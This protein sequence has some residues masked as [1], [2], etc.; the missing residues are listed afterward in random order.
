MSGM[1]KKHRDILTECHVELMQDLEPEKVFPLLI[2]ERVLTEDDQERISKL[3]TRKDR[4]EELLRKLKG[5][6]PC[7]FGV[8]VKALEKTQSHLACLLREGRYCNAS[9]KMSRLGT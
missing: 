8:F 1:E 5:C 3:A 7:A 6:G 4:S 9:P 2:Q